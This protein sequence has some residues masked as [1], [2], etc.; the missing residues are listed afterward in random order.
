M[1]KEERRPRTIKASLNMTDKECYMLLYDICAARNMTL[2]ELLDAFIRSLIDMC[3]P[4]AGVMPADVSKASDF[5]DKYIG[6]ATDAENT[7]LRHIVCE[8]APYDPQDY[9][10]ALSEI[11]Q[12]EKDK[13][14]YSEHPDRDFD[15]EEMTYIDDDIEGY[16]RWISDMHRDWSKDAPD[17][18]GELGLIGRW[19]SERSELMG[20]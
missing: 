7:L 3:V 2:S 6:R 20:W 12:L 1:T 5:L 15:R 4:A 11:E 9:T 17:M 18:D 10:D 8:C 14:E 13:K 19:L 16:N